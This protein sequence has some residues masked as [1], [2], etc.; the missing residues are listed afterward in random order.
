MSTFKKSLKRVLKQIWELF[1]L[2]FPPMLLYGSCGAI[3]QMLTL[4][5]GGTLAWDSKKMLWTI[6]CWLLAVGYNAGVSYAYGGTAYEML[7]SGNMKRK[8]AT[9]GTEIKMSKHKEEIEYRAWKGF[10]VGA[11]ICIFMLIFGIIFAVK[12]DEINSIFQADNPGV[13][14]QMGALVLVGILLS[15][16]TLLPCF[17]LNGA[18]IAIHY[19]FTLFLIIIPIAVTGGFYIAGAY[20]KRNKNMRLRAKEEAEARAKEARGGKVNYGGLPGTKPK[21]RK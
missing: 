12:N 19:G 5:E 4:K 17:Y 3:L 15:G 6:I 10:A 2:A 9:F 7:V 1:K 16:L 13:G 14:L 8:S 18:G 11:I 21:K 20:G